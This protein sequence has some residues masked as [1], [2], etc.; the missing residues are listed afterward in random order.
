MTKCA[1]VLLDE[2]VPLAQLCR[3]SVP[4][5][6]AEEISGIRA[7]CLEPDGCRL[8]KHICLQRVTATL[9]SP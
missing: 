8:I 6:R 4:T 9:G 1:C 5:S 3:G 7:E 2:E